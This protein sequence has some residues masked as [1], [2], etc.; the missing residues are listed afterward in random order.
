ME[1][2]EALYWHFPAYLQGTRKTGQAFR[3]RPAG[4]IRLGDWKLLEF[5]E[6]HRVELY[7]LK[8]DIGEQKNLAT[9]NPKKTKELL[10][11][12]HGWQKKVDAPIPS[13]LNPDYAPSKKR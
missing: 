7:N 11:L 12:L 9:S 8:D 3:T 10:D 6:N 4:A 1:L 5:F 13:E 2:R